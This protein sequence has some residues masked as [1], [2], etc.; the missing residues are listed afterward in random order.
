MLA[1][2]REDRRKKFLET[3][4]PYREMIDAIIRKEKTLSNDASGDRKKTARNR[5]DL[6]EEMFN[7]ASCYILES[8]IYQRFFG[9]H[10]TDLLDKARKAL[11]RGVDYIEELVSPWID[12]PFSE[13]EDKL[14]ALSGVSADKRYFVIRKMGLVF[15]IL[16]D[17]FGDSSKWKWS[18]VVLEGRL[19]AA[20][21]NM[22]N[23]K[24]MTANLDP[25]SEER[26]VTVFHLRRVKKMLTQAAEHHREKY[27]LSSRDT[28]DF[29]QAIN[30]LNALRR[31]HVLL[32][33][34][35]EAEDLK[36]T[37]EAWNNK[38]QD[39]LRKKKENPKE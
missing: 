37:V 27:E 26:E 9:K 4:A 7:L 20:A 22:L 36:K 30:F 1:I 5:L 29:Q 6:A 35:S 28:E 16:K 2:S 19:A 8:R 18:F 38:L 39:D 33:E 14:A 23:M 3:A 15:D 21:K 25:R 17:V 10:D 13:Y 31:L 11:F 24:N 34:K 12:V 32:N